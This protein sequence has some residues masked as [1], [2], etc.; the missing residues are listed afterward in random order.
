MEDSTHALLMQDR[1]EEGVPP[2]LLA[3]VGR[4]RDQSQTP[5]TDG[6]D[7]ALYRESGSS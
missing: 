5:M 3:C 2:L 4:G 1:A 7:N 6:G